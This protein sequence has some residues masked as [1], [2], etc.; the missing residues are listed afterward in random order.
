MHTPV[1]YKN[2]KGI[3]C[4]EELDVDVMIMFQEVWCMFLLCCPPQACQHQ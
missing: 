3:D 4:L 2:L 1:W